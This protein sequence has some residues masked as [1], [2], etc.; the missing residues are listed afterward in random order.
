MKEKRN[1]RI[2]NSIDSIR[3]RPGMF[4]GDTSNCNHLIHELIDNSLDEIRNKFGD[5]IS[6]NFSKKGDV[7]ICDNGRGLPSGETID[8]NTGEKVD[9]LE[10]LFTKLHS[11]TKFSFDSDQLESLF[12]QNG[13]G[14]V[15]VN[16]LSEYVEVLSKMN[17]YR[18][19]DSKLVVKETVDPSDTWSTQIMFRPNKQYFDSIAPDYNTFLLRCRLA[20]AKLENI[21]FIF[22]KKELKRESLSD[23]V[24]NVLHISKNTPLFECSFKTTK[25]KVV[26]PVTNKE[27]VLPGSI[28]AFITYEP[29]ETVITG[30]VNLRFCDGVYINNVV[31]IIKANLLSKLDKKYSKTPERFLIEGL[32]LYISLQMPFPKFDS[33]TK[34]RMISDV[35]KEVIDG[36]FESKIIK[37]LGEQYI[38][39]TVSKIL[40]QKL[41]NITKIVKKKI[42][43]E[44]KLCDCS[45][46][47]GDVLYIIE[48]DSAAA[49]VR[50]CRDA[51]REAYLPLRGKVINIEKQSLHKIKENKE[52]KNIIEAIGA[53][54][55]RYEKI[56]I[57]ADA[58]CLSEDT[59][60]T[61]KDV[62]DC[63]KQ[64][65]ISNL[66]INNIKTVFSYNFISNKYEESKVLNII[67]KA[68][69]K[70]FIEFTL[71]GNEKIQSYVD[72]GFPV[73]DI[74]KNKVVFLNA[75][76][77]D[78]NIH[79]FLSLKNKFK[80]NNNHNIQLNLCDEF[81][82]HINRRS[83]SI[84]V[85]P[86]SN[87]DERKL[88]IY[89]NRNNISLKHI[90][91]I[92]NTDQIF[93]NGN[94]ISLYPII[95]MYH[96]YLIG[97]YIGDGCFGSSKK[98]PYTILISCNSNGKNIEKIKK[99]CEYL[100]YGCVIDKRKETKCTTL[101]IKSLELY[102]ILH[103]LGFNRNIRADKKFIPS[104][105]ITASDD[106]KMNL[107]KGM[108]SADGSF[109]EFK[110]SQKLVYTTVSEKLK[111][112][113]YLI[114][115]NFNVNTRIVKSP[116]KI[117]GINNK[118]I[119]IIGRKNKYEII[120]S[121]NL[122][123][124]W[125]ICTEVTDL[126]YIQHQNKKNNNIINIDSDLIGIKIKSIK[127]IG[128]LDR[129][130][131]LEV[132]KT[133]NFTIGN[134][135][136]LTFN[137]DGL[138]INVLVILLINKFFPDIIK[139]GRLS[140][141]LPPLYGAYKNKTFIPLYNVTDA[142]KY[143]ESGYSIQ[144]FK[145][146]GEMNSD[147]MRAVFDSETEYVIS[148]SSHLDEL[149]KII[150]NSDVKRQYLN[151]EEEYN[152]KDFI[153]TVFN[154][155][156]QKRV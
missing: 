6:L 82:K 97:V 63:I 131:C 106:I 41:N 52:I 141:V 78:I 31:N 120:C 34:T 16:A 14:L 59:L 64:E 129:A 108:Y 73:Y 150:T 1:V 87:K 26:E 130:Y 88:T 125:D 22:N 3:L 136:I 2:L 149:L 30:D 36:Q 29:G 127:N 116:P 139:E 144:R 151:L 90:Q 98:N 148:E 11:G 119:Q 15:A 143:A 44:N 99:Y 93:Q 42:S 124:V 40:S 10:S 66:D 46:Q 62:Y 81:L 33:Q 103:K 84:I 53:P 25:M 43:S 101:Q 111:N 5:T 132:E 146:L 54:P 76:Q 37:I 113:L 55:H 57:V 152:F 48:G 47:P 35:K 27:F 89:K 112:D 69:T 8:E 72:H 24:R 20:Q 114:L 75:N 9:A 105:F 56:K 126:Q 71:Y 140:V 79:Y 123:N 51:S 118:N 17:H 7:L 156:N 74:Q 154:N 77:I 122:N 65:K 96:A 68:A 115:N 61:Y 50:E 13:V 91:Y 133:H 18:F 147:Q 104:V 135:Q 83:T 28:V 110:N 39:D 142:N 67:N 134:N 45:Q 92:K 95:N 138:H 60:I 38:K 121:Q 155:L 86:I 70:D 117:G 137:C 85:K 49:P 145:G 94:L 21:K 109:N 12:G 102:L 80:F 107:L 58:D 153:Q 19:V 100:N 32:R 23:F 4:V 128:K